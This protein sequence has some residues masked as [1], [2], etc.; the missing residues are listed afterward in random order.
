[1]PASQSMWPALQHCQ[2]HLLSLQGFHLQRRL[3]CYTFQVFE[4]KHNVI[5]YLQVDTPSALAWLCAQSATRIN[6]SCIEGPAA[7]ALQAKK[8]LT[9]QVVQCQFL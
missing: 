5:S 6:V 7:D 3:L 2:H 4:T 1:M 9:Q 8:L